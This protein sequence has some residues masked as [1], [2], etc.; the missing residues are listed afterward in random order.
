MSD[1]HA[2]GSG[3][4]V[5]FMDADLNK[6]A[7]D[8]NHTRVVVKSPSGLLWTVIAQLSGK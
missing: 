1:E 8:K 7:S 3:K 2:S 5:Y 4:F 6:A